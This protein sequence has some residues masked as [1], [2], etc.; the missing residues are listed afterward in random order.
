MIKIKM[1]NVNVTSNSIHCFAVV[2]EKRSCAVVA[3]KS[4]VHVMSGSVDSENTCGTTSH[5][6]LIESPVG[7]KISI[8][9]LDFTSSV[10]DDGKMSCRSYGVIV[11]RT[12]KR[13]TSICGRND[14]RENSIY[15]SI[16]NS[17]VIFFHSSSSVADSNDESRS[18]LLKI[19]GFEPNV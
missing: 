7:Q 14:E 12:A 9:L 3:S 2:D 4:A 10:S 13:N 8:S 15:L 5:P 17:V 19:E 11:D 6:W 18:F 16:G 1:P